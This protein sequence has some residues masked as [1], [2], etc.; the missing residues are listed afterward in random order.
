M[1]KTEDIYYYASGDKLGD[2]RNSYFYTTY[3]GKAFFDCWK[4]SREE[5]GISKSEASIVKLFGDA[6]IALENITSVLLSEEGILAEDMLDTLNISFD[7]KCENP[8]ALKHIDKLVKRF[9]VT[10][11]V[12]SRYQ[13]NRYV[14]ADKEA[15]RDLKLYLKMAV[16]FSK[17]YEQ[18]VR[19]PYLNALLKIIDSLSSQMSLINHEYHFYLEYLVTKEKEYISGLAN[20]LG[21]EI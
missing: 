2:G 10:K 4:E 8:L 19:L 14:A 18:T 21:V 17:G 1:K 5:L 20:K 15:Y 7:E 6:S 11:R 12:Y 16:I 13:G 9:E 3:H